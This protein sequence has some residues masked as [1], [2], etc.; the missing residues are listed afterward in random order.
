MAL[1]S[2]RLVASPRVGR[3]L[4]DNQ[5]INYAIQMLRTGDQQDYGGRERIRSDVILPA[6]E[7]IICAM[8]A[9]LPSQ[10]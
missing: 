2:A 1:H 7:R 6:M 10:V 8:N 9:D 4:M 5:G 3:A